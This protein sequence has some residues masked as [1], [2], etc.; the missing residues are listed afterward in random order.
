MITNS[1]GKTFPKFIEGYGECIPF[2]GCKSEPHPMNVNNAI[3]PW[4]VSKP[5]EV[6]LLTNLEEA[7]D[8]CEIKDGMTISFHHHLRNGDIIAN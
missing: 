2:N 4:K 8:K 3:P 6:K 7:L 1:L 5:G